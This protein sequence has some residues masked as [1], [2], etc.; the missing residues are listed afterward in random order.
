MEI[1]TALVELW[2]EG[3]TV[4]ALLISD[5]GMVM[6]AAEPRIDGMTVVTSTGL[7]LAELIVVTVV[8][9]TSAGEGVV[10]LAI[11]S[12]VKSTAGDVERLGAPSSL[13]SVL[14]V[15]GVESKFVVLT[16]AGSPEPGAKLDR[17][18]LIV[19]D[20]SINVAEVIVVGEAVGG[21]V[22]AASVIDAFDVPGPALSR[23]LFSSD[24]DAGG[25]VVMLGSAGAAPVSVLV[26]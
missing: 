2:Y 19:V 12:G 22:D 5:H 24:A 18:T 26:G 4:V 8:T 20:W 21:S 1:S 14:F 17:D 23:I 16:S 7:K 6:D 9:N 15:A 10:V 11:G 13:T 3:V 25:T